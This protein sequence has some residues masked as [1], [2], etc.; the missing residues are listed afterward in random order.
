MNKS[1]YKSMMEQAVPSAALIQE[2]KCKM[3]EKTATRK[4]R[5]FPALATMA[6]VL[7]LIIGAYALLPAQISNSFTVRAYAI[8]QQADGT[9]ASR[10]FGLTDPSAAWFGHFDSGYWYLGI[11]LD[12]EGE[13][14][15]SVE[16]H[17]ADGYFAKHYIPIQERYAYLDEDGNK[18]IDWTIN[19]EV[20]YR[21][22]WYV[23]EDGRE[24]RTGE[25]VGDNTATIR[26]IAFVIDEFG[27]ERITQFGDT[28]EPM[29]STIALEE[30]QSDNLLLFAATP[31]PWYRAPDRTE[32]QVY[33]VF[34]DGERQSE[35][36]VIEFGVGYGFGM[37]FDS[38]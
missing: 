24:I 29:G 13:N 6:A 34:H 26:S 17:I 38:D 19:G 16:F 35:T 5:T 36:I 33:V 31:S 12:V 37:G 22:R 11:D 2:T 32:I 25:F 4:R 8:E 27:N 10:E 28:F 18:V 7:T 30:I 15:A 14:I 1:D 21:S 20:V 9:I 3:M 23:D